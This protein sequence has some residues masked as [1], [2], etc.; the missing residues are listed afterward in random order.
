[1]RSPIVTVTGAYLISNTELLRPWL[2]LTDPRRSLAGCDA[3]PP[4][5]VTY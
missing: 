2:S 3:I 4:A 5:T 1:M